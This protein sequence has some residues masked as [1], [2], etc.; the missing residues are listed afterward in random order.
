MKKN[1]QTDKA[2]KKTAAKPAE[3]EVISLTHVRKKNTE[4]YSAQRKKSLKEK[5]NKRSEKI[6]RVYR[7]AEKIRQDSAVAAAFKKI[8][9]RYY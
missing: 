4:K 6:Q 2:V 1:E 9:S 8:A 3:E 7:S 5:L